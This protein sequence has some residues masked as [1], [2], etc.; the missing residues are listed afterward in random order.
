MILPLFSRG[1]ASECSHGRR[2]LLPKSPPKL[3]GVAR[4]AGVVPGDKMHRSR[5][6]KPKHFGTGT[7]PSAPPMRLRDSES[8]ESEQT[9]VVRH[10]NKILV[11][12][13]IRS[14]GGELGKTPEGRGNERVPR[15]LSHRWCS[16]GERPNTSGL[17]P[18]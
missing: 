7:T 18:G 6:A 9:G 11:T 16:C 4:S 1:A 5:R 2:G 10:E 13:P 3:G 15:T 14:L 17:A 8:L 12:S